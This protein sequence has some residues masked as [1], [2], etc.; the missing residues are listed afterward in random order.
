MKYGLYMYFRT[1]DALFRNV[2]YPKDYN[3]ENGIYSPELG[4]F[5]IPI[6][7]QG[8]VSFSELRTFEIRDHQRIEPLELRTSRATILRIRLHLV[9][10]HVT[11]YISFSTKLIFTCT[12]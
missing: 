11:L 6:A 2:V 1:F 7:K 10:R 9:K 5:V 3:S 12:C 8:F 4:R